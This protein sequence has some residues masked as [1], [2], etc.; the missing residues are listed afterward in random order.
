MMPARHAYLEFT[1]CHGECRDL[2][3]ASGSAFVFEERSTKRNSGVII[4]PTQTEVTGQE[5]SF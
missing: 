5:L 2:P 1:C 4:G 3:Q